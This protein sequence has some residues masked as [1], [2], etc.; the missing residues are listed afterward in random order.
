M[1][2][3]FNNHNNRRYVCFVCGLSIE[4]P[5]EYRSHIVD[6]HELG[7][8]YVVCPLQRCGFPVRCVR[9]HFKAHHP[10]ES[11]PKVA[12]TKSTIWRDFNSKGEK[13]TRRA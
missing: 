12:Q 13:K 9:T 8:D 5:A 4:D 2:L 10:K 7:R 3:D 11:I 6:N 1:S